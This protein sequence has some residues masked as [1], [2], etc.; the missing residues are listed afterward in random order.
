MSEASESVLIDETKD[1]LQETAD[2]MNE[3]ANASPEE[4]KK[5][6]CKNRR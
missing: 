4:S 2:L 3:A 6:L 1:V 5:D